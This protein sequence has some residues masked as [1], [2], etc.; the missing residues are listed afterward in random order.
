MS[1]IVQKSRVR[2]LLEV[3]SDQP[4][5]FAGVFFQRV[6]IQ[7]GHTLPAFCKTP[8]ARV[9]LLAECLTSVPGSPASAGAPWNRCGA[10]SSIA[11]LPDAGPLDEDGCKRKSEPTAPPWPVRNAAD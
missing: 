10:R 2:L 9:T 11:I 6:A 8:A 1:V 5:T 3:L 4:V 7:D